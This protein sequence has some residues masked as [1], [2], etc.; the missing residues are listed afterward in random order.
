MEKPPIRK[1]YFEAE[2]GCRQWYESVADGPAEE[3]V[4]VVEYCQTHD[5]ESGSA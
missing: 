3:L 4:E 5:I 2:C 1:D